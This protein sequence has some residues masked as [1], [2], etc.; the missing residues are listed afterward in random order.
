MPHDQAGL[1]QFAALVRR[2]TALV[3]V[4]GGMLALAV[5]VLVVVSVLGRWLFNTPIE[6]DFEFVKMATA[7]AVFSYLPYAQMRRENIMVDTFTTRLPARMR[8]LLDAFWDMAYAA[9]AG[10][11]AY[12]L[13][14]G[15]MQAARSG[16]STM[17]L[18]I[19]IWPAIAVSAVLAAL[20]TLTAILSAAELLGERP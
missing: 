17:Q 1:M 3:A 8:R 15:A 5:A 9:F 12:G 18:Q 11:I 10:L 13:A 7:I 14:Y 4:F 20:L 16:E 19:V 2:L 6:G